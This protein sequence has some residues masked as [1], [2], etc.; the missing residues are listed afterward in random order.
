MQ[1]TACLQ[2]IGQIGCEISPNTQPVYISKFVIYRLQSATGKPAPVLL[3][4]GRLSSP[5]NSTS[6]LF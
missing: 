1:N 6:K 3:Q 2:V 5:I 4:A